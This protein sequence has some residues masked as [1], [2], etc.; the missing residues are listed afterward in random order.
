MFNSIKIKVFIYME[1]KIRKVAFNDIK[2]WQIADFIDPCIVYGFD[3]T[4][5]SFTI[6]R[7]VEVKDDKFLKAKLCNHVFIPDQIDTVFLLFRPISL[8]SVIALYSR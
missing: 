2:H 4:L 3:T 8:A 5:S 1:L 6:S 7:L